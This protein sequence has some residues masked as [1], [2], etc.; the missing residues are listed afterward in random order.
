MQAGGLHSTEMRSCFSCLLD[1][2]YLF[3]VNAGSVVEIPWRGADNQT[4]PYAKEFVEVVGMQ[5]LW[6]P[7]LVYKPPGETFT[8]SWLSPFL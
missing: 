3:S 4:L 7:V 5:K 1:D 8:T 6:A 2:T